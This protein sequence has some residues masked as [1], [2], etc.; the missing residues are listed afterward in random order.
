MNDFLVLTIGYYSLNNFELLL[1][2]LLLL[3]G[4]IVC[5]ILNKNQKNI[6][7]SFILN[8]SL[9]LKNIF[10]TVNFFFLRKQNLNKQALY[11]PNIRMYKK[12]KS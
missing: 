8:S 11:K 9:F 5:V 4:S 1:I 3:V 12:K 2:G 7:N 10:N 6:K